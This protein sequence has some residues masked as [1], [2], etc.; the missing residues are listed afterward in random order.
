MLNQNW[1]GELSILILP[2]L[3]N[4]KQPTGHKLYEKQRTHISED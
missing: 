3:L 2:A 4:A 1:E